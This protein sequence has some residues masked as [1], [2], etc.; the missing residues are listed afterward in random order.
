MFL[1]SVTG[2]FHAM[3]ISI[4]KYS[5]MEQNQSGMLGEIIQMLLVDCLVTPFISI[6][7]HSRIVVITGIMSIMSQHLGN[8]YEE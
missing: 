7:R 4:T 3:V 8:K 6:A 2:P 1:T 5:L